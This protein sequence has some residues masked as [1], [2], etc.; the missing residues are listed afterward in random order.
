MPVVAQAAPCLLLGEGPTKKDIGSKLIELEVEEDHDLA[1]VFRIKLAIV[2]DE[3]GLWTLLDRD[4]AKPWQKLEITMNVGG[5]EESVMKGYVTQLRVHIG[6]IEGNSYL[7]IAGMD[8]SCLM[9]LEEVIKDWPGVS[10]S[11]IAEKI[12]GK[13][14]LSSDVDATD[15][16]HDP[17]VSTVIQRES[18][19]QF[20]KRLARRNGYECLVAGGMGYFKKVDAVVA[21]LPELAA[22]FGGATNLTSFDANW[23]GLRPTAVEVH[24]VDAV[25]KQV[26]SVVV[27]KSALAPLGKDGPPAPP[28]PV[29]GKPRTVLRHSVA[30][31]QPEMTAL[32]NG[33]ADEASWFV[34]GRGEVDGTVYGAMLHVRKLVPIKGVGEL[35]SGLYYLTSVKHV[36]Q[37]DRYTQ[38]FTA[39]RNATKTKPADF[40]ASKPS[41]F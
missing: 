40:P 17:A 8:S 12:F 32:A 15:V 23:N 16:V 33:L 11:Q 36:Y 41:P 31:G 25:T 14:G 37:N 1:G 38:H 28:L 13:Y 26:Q 18:D 19:I 27:A 29:G 2:R 4:P 20:L 9:S 39:R 30:T 10:D 21:R 5:R 6:V 35:F 7:E 22:H 3:G 24:Q 34:E